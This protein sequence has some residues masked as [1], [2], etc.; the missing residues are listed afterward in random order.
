MDIRNKR[1]TREEIQ[2]N[3]QTDEALTPEELEYEL[4]F[5]RKRA[6]GEQIRPRAQPKR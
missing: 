2:R 5:G 4:R 3:Q 1:P 6:M